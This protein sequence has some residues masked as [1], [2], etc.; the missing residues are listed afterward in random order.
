MA[1]KVMSWGVQSDQ[2][3]RSRNW[4]CPNDCIRLQNIST[5]DPGFY[6]IVV[7]FDTDPPFSDHASIEYIQACPGA[8]I[9]ECPKCFE[10]FYFH[11]MRSTVHGLMDYCP[12][13]PNTP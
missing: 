6:K 12:N 1:K 4:D 5:Y 9:I 2:A 10:K 13:W 11:V 7:G 8:V 3:V